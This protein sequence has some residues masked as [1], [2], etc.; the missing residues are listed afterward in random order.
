MNMA[1]KFWYIE[2]TFLKS[3]PSYILFANLLGFKL[4]YIWQR[5]MFIYLEEF[6]SSTILKIL[7]ILKVIYETSKKYIL[8]YFIN[9][10]IFMIRNYEIAKWKCWQLLI[11]FFQYIAKNIWTISFNHFIDK[12]SIEQWKFQSSNFA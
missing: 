8:T 12:I 6:I 4:R 10:I 2:L 3:T 7:H 5:K 1:L 11:K 9:L